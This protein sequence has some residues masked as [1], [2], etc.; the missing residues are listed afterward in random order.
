MN[1]HPANKKKLLLGSSI[2]PVSDTHPC[3]VLLCP[4]YSVATTVRLGAHA[5]SLESNSIKI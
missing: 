5:F 2:I 4:V 1:L 3:M